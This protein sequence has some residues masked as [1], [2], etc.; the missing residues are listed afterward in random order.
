LTADTTSFWG[1]ETSA[2]GVNLNG[3]RFTIYTGGGNAHTY[4][5][6]I[7]GP[8]A[9]G[10]QG[11]GDA[12]WVPDMQLGGTVAN[13]PDGVTIN[14]GR[15][16]LNKTDGVD[17][18]AGA[19]TVNPAGG[20]TAIIQLL[21]SNQINDASTITTTA[22]AGAFHLEMGGF[23]ETISGLIIKAGDTVNTGTGGVLT[24]THL[25][26]SGEVKGP[27]TYT[28]SDA[29]VAGTGSVVVPGGSAYDAWA[30]THAGGQTSEKDYNNDGVSNGVAYFMGATGLATNPGVVAGKVTWPRDPTAVVSSFKVQVS[31]NLTV[32]TDIVPP[33]ASIDESIPTQVTYTLPTGAAE[34]FCRLVVT[35]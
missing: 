23:S 25:T 10:F 30:S 18:L 35:P 1:G 24:V 21:K 5:G 4:N 2:A 33:N 11:R 9:L 34:E 3:F 29:F 32:W 12:S 6:A 15:V 8:G 16:V 17:A 27:G 28:S 26:V 14:T 13:S 7:T 20:N 31:D 19:I 22:G